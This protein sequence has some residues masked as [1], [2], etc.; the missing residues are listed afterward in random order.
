MADP[1]LGSLPSTTQASFLF[2]DLPRRSGIAHSLI[3]LP[4]VF[5]ER[6]LSSIWYLLC[7]NLRSPTKVN[8]ET[9]SP[10]CIN[11]EPLF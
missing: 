10:E 11:K 9:K 5:E 8:K 4:G 3:L 2:L 7:P 1:A 6:A